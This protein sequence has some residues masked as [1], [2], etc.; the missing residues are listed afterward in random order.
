[1]QASN[2]MIQVVIFI[3]YIKLNRYYHTLI[4]NI[5]SMHIDKEKE[6][7]KNYSCEVITY[8]IFSDECLLEA[9]KIESDLWSLSYL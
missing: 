9:L 5:M 3:L 7:K 6:K 8:T 1:M 4:R 2:I